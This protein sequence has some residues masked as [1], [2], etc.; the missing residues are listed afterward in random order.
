MDFIK[1]KK[2]TN[3]SITHAHYYFTGSTCADKHQQQMAAQTSY[4]THSLLQFL[5]VLFLNSNDFFLTME[6]L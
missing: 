4:L 2:R 6:H 3:R 5:L 1:K